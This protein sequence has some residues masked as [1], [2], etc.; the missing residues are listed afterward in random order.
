MKDK[1]LYGTFDYSPF[2]WLTSFFYGDKFLLSH[3]D[4]IEVRMSRSDD[5]ETNGSTIIFLRTGRV[6]NVKE[7]PHEIELLV[8]YTNHPQ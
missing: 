5:G 1:D 7:T 3:E 6:L 8:N 4:I 2:I